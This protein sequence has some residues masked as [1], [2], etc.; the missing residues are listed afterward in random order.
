MFWWREGSSFVLQAGYGVPA[1]LSG[2]VAL[3]PQVTG[4]VRKE[5]F[6]SL[7]CRYE[8]FFLSGQDETLYSTFLLV[9]GFICFRAHTAPVWSN[10]VLQ[11]ECVGVE[12]F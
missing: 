12:E 5:L 6:E 7:S 4:E 10:G 9:E 1:V 11:T 2:L 3:E 8:E